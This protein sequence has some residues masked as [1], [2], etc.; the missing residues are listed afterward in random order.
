[1]GCGSTR[2]HENVRQASHSCW[3]DQQLNRDLHLLYASRHTVV[4]R[5]VFQIAGW[6]HLKLSALTPAS[7]PIDV[8]GW[9]P[10]AC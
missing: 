1:M 10:G 8:V 6:V 9:D 7:R 4:L 2:G 3:Y 5:V